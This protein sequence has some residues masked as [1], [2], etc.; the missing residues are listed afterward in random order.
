MC[1]PD[2]LFGPFPICTTREERK[3]LF[4]GLGTLPIGCCS[5]GL[6]VRDKS[7]LPSVVFQVRDDRPACYLVPRPIVCSKADEKKYL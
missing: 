7:A 3:I 6:L 2:G 1:L 5:T 4:S